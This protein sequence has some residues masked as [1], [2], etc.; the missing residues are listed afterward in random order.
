MSPLLSHTSSKS[1]SAN[2]TCARSRLSASSPH[3]RECCWMRNKRGMLEDA[4]PSACLPLHSTL[5][6]V[7]A[8]I[9]SSLL[10]TQNPAQTR[11][12]EMDA[13]AP[14]PSTLVKER[15][16]VNKFPDKPS[17]A[18]SW[19]IPLDPLGFVAPGGI[20]LGARNALASLGF[21]DEDHL[22]FTFR[23]PGLQHREATGE[24]DSTERQIRAIVL[25]LPQG[26]IESEAQ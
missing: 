1:G 15:Y 20:Y 26:T 14:Q 9:F 6:I 18:P 4:S 3:R 7:A 21:L 16:L 10:A 23:V 12:P 25:T 22:L 24:E 13:P 17:I 2:G 5:A 19:S 8:V 11:H